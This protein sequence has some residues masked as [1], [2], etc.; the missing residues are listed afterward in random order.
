MSTEHIV[1]AARS[2]CRARHGRGRFAC[3]QCL[4]AVVRRPAVSAGVALGRRM[5]EAVRVQMARVRRARMWRAAGESVAVITAHFGVTER[6]LMTWLGGGVPRLRVSQ[7][8][9]HSGA[10]YEQA[11]EYVRGTVECPVR[12]LVVAA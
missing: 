4:V 11:L 1:S 5:G 7:V 6:E 12:D 8:M 10:T 2:R 3:R 9:T